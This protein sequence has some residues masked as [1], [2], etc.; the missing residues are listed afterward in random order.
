MNQLLPAEELARGR[1]KQRL[2]NDLGKPD[3]R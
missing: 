3:V 1:W 2:A